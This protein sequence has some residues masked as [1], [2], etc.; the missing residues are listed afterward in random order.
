LEHN[1]VEAPAVGSSA[2]SP[3]SESVQ[4]V[5]ILLST[6]KTTRPLFLEEAARV[7]RQRLSLSLSLVPDEKM[8]GE[9][10]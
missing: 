4:E 2:N 5:V 9:F 8:E 6:T 10:F 3:S 1:V 7:Q